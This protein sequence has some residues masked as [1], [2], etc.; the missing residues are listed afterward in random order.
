MCQKGNHIGEVQDKT[1]MSKKLHVS[2]E[3]HIL[4]VEL[5]VVLDP[6][7]PKGH[8]KTQEKFTEGQKVL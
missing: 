8:I 7:S 1:N 5:C 3:I 2:G 6:S 4:Q